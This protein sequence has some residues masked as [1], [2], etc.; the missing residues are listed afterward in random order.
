MKPAWDDNKGMERWVNDQLDELD[1]ANPDWPAVAMERHFAWVEALGPEIDAADHGDIAPLR[2]KLPH[3]ARFLQLPK[4]PDGKR[5]ARL[6]DAYPDLVAIVDAKRIRALW[7]QHYGKRNRSRDLISAEKI[8]ARRW[9][10][11]VRDIINRTKNTGRI[12]RTKS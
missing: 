2:A 11:T 9:G 12:R 10:I 8:A 7:L 5:F 4:Q 3:L 1:A 6:D